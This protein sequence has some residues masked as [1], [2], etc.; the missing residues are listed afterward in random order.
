MRSSH[1]QAQTHTL[2]HLRQK[3]G[4]QQ[5]TFS[6]K[7]LFANI[8]VASDE[9]RRRSYSVFGFRSAKCICEQTI[10]DYNAL[11]DQWNG[12]RIKFTNQIMQRL[13]VSCSSSSFVV[14]RSLVV[15]AFPL[16]ASI[17]LFVCVSIFSHLKFTFSGQHIHCLS[18][19]D[20]FSA[21][22]R[23]I[24]C[25]LGVMRRAAFLLLK[26]ANLYYLSIS[27]WIYCAWL[28]F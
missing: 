17:S 19:L 8:D 11:C 12:N 28:N 25:M 3:M 9:I 27:K 10:W 6:L 24:Y 5:N 7:I 4:K 14:A 16:C 21:E 13:F 23:F 15:V 26:Y 1:T 18:L 20:S 2:V 22:L